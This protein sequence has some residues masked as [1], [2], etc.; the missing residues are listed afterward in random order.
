MILH[1][2]LQRYSDDGESSLGLMFTGF[3]KAKLPFAGYT[4]EDEARAVKVAKE[5]RIPAGIY[6]LRLLKVLSPMTERYRAKF[7]DWFTWHVQ[8]MNVQN[9]Q[10]VYI[11]IGNEEKDTD[12]CVLLGDTANNNAVADGFIGESTQAYKRW[13]QQVVPHLE[14]GGQAF[15]EIRDEISLFR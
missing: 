13:Y 7:P 10:Y 8:I 4:L 5:T 11:H 2:L 15:I 1:N 9:F 3:D 12:A 6:E 14:A